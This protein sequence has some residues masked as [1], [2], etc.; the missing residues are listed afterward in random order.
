LHD[1]PECKNQPTYITKN[2]PFSIKITSPK[3]DN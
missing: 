2:H 3:Y 1:W